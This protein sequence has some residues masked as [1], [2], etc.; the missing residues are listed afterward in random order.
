MAAIVRNHICFTKEAEAEAKELI[1]SCPGGMIFE[2]KTMQQAHA[3][4]AAVK[5]VFD[6]DSRVF[7]D[8]EAAERSHHYPFVQ[9]PPVVHV[10]RPTWGIPFQL[11]KTR[12]VDRKVDAQLAEMRGWDANWPK[13]RQMMIEKGLEESSERNPYQRKDA[14]QMVAEELISDMAEEFGGSFVGT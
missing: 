11:P 9:E 14:E 2:F 10:D 1:K 3:F 7:D 6:L 12:A 8:V 13:L 5:R 4:A